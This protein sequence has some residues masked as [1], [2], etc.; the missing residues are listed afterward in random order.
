MLGKLRLELAPPLPQW[1]HTPLALT[2]RGFT[3]GL[4]PLA[5]RSVEAA[6]DLAD[7][8]LELVTSDGA[9]RRVAVAPARPINDVWADYVAALRQLGV[10]LQAWDRPQERDDS[11][12]FSEDA[13][14]R[15]FDTEVATAHHGLLTELHDVFERWRSPFFGRTGLGFWWGGFDISLSLY[16]G[17]KLALREGVNYIQRYDLDAEHATIGFWPGDEENE[18]MFFGYIVPEPPGCADYPLRPEA[19]AWAPSM[20]EWVLPYDRIR[21][22][23]FRLKA[24]QAFIDSIYRAAGELGGWPLSDFTYDAPPSRSPAR[25]RAQAG[26]ER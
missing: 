26:A 23:E 21:Q 5:G 19:A 22:Q 16:T 9:R 11:T 20:S 4:L 7:G 14:P 13:R 17:R 12:P 1:S 15:E 8:S 10:E 18:A 3:T 25:Q 2:P 24:V 6:L